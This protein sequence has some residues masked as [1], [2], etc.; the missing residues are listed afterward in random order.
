MFHKIDDILRHAII[1]V[2]M[3]DA[4]SRRRRNNEDHELQAKARRKKEDLAKEK[5][6]GKATEEYIKASY[7]IGIINSDVC[8]KN[9]PKNVEKLLKKLT[10]MT[11]KYD[12]L[13]KNIVI[14][15][16]GF[17]WEWCKHAWT[18]NWRKFAGAERANHLHWIIREE[19][20]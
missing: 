19:N 16:K 5:N 9:N 17:N 6:M 12:A 7:L 10:S 15:V 11:A 14:L 2:A 20:R 4:L 1:L 13:K 18:K 3:P 8:V